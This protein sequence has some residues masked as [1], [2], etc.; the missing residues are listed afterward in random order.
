MM[1]YSKNTYIKTKFCNLLPG[2]CFIL[3]EDFEKECPG[4]FIK[5]AAFDKAINSFD[6]IYND[7]I[8]TEDEASVYPIDAEL[9]WNFREGKHDAI[10]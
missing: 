4:I 9:L 1:Q 8:S 6:F 5:T 10:Q 7:L 3:E 2:E